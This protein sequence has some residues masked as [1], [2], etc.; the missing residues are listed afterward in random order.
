MTM[1]K[2]ILTLIPKD[3]QEKIKGWSCSYYQPID[4]KSKKFHTHTKNTFQMT[5]MIRS[6]FSRRTLKTLKNNNT[7]NSQKRNIETKTNN[8][9]QKE[10]IN[11]PL[12]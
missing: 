3:S 12:H 1:T 9:P 2:K 10:A 6:E 11:M 7:D 4:F 8:T 5:K